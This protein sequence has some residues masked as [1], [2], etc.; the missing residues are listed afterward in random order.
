MSDETASEEP[1]ELTSSVHGPD[2]EDPE[3]DP[4]YQR[5]RQLVLR[6]GNVF[7]ILVAM[8]LFLPMLVGVGQG[9]ADKK[10]WDPYTGKPVYGQAEEHGACVEEARL[11][12]MEAGRHERLVRTWAEPYRE[13]QTRCRKK[14][15]RLYEAL[16]HT[17]DELRRR[18][19]PGGDAPPQ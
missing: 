15:P 14:H 4:V 9:I 11:L 2:Q 13:W 6:V 1:R 5:T 3:D 10:V 12:L 19:G 18:K 7:F 17:R 16:S 8:G